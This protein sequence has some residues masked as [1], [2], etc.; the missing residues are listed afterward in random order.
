[1]LN[2]PLVRATGKIVGSLVLG[3]LIVFTT[4]VTVGLAGKTVEKLTNIRKLDERIKKG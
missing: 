3:E 2:N 1:M 4:L